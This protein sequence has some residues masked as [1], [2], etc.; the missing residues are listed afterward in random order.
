VILFL[1]ARQHFV[2]LSIEEALETG[3]HDL[4]PTPAP[5]LQP[6]GQ[7]QEQRMHFQIHFFDSNKTLIPCVRHE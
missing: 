5:D 3:K 2:S 6:A 4:L 7:S 1:L